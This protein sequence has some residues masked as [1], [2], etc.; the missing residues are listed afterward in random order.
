MATF[1]V[2]PGDSIQ[3]A[4]NAASPGDTIIVEAG[5][6]NQQVIIDKSLTLLGAQQGVDARTRTG[7]DE[8]IVT[9]V[10]GGGNG[11]FIVNADNVVIDGFTIE[12]NTGGSGIQ[13][14]PTFSGYGIYNNIIQDNRMGIHL[15]SDGTIASEVQFNFFARNVDFAGIYSDQ[16]GASNVVIRDNLFR[17]HDPNVASVNF[18]QN[19]SNILIENNDINDSSIAVIESEDVTIRGNQLIGIP[20]S[21][22]FISGGTNNISILENIIYDNNRGININ[23]IFSQ[24]PNT[25]ITIHQNCIQGNDIGLYMQENSYIG[26]LD[27]TNNWW[28][29]PS[30]PSGEG[31]GTGDSI[32]DE[33][34]LGEVLFDPWL[35]VNPCLPPEP[36]PSPTP[37]PLQA[38]CIRVQKVFDWVYLTNRYQNKIQF[39][40]ACRP[41]IEERL[42]LGH[43]L[44][45]QCSTNPDQFLP[46]FPLLPK[47]Q[48]TPTP[49]VCPG[50]RCD[51]DVEAAT[52]V[53]CIAPDGTNVMLQA[54]PFLFTVCVRVDLHDVN[55]GNEI[56]CSENVFV[57]FDEE[58]ALCWQRGLN[59]Q[60]RILDVL[61]NAS[62]RQAGAGAFM[63]PGIFL[64]VNVCKEIQVEAEVK[65][66]LFA[67]FCQPRRAVDCQFAPVEAS[68]PPLPSN[69][70]PVQCPTIFPVR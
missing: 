54:I 5:T 23:I 45:A 18:A 61:C 67:R 4:V 36:N 25:N 28:G 2:S 34:L 29:D 24:S 41:I 20:A 59:I 65:L 26:V 35:L 13:T 64:T 22:I 42:A 27:A 48:P 21:A 32:I 69:L 19:A 38:E 55:A 47:P 51:F 8:S 49:I 12:G 37:E 14:S 70:F 44:V 58:V 15:L 46:V 7:A 53:R 60:C 52:E 30:G 39:S 16:Q 50:A 31:P 1:T 6:Y 56:I 17:G 66:E 9:F 43:R 68:C 62:F 63:E 3:A 40:E 57:Q 11:I 10:A 33:N